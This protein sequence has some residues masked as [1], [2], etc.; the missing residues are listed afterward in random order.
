MSA[1]NAR[2]EDET[3]SKLTESRAALDKRV[4]FISRRMSRVKNLL[5]EVDSDVPSP[6]DFVSWLAL[7]DG[8]SELD[9]I[10]PELL[11]LRD[12]F[13][14]ELEKP[15][16][17]ARLK[18]RM[19][20][21]QKLEM[22]AEQHGFEIEKIGESPLVYF[23]DPLTLE[24]DFDRGSAMILY[25]KE[26]IREVAVSAKAVA[27]AYREIA[28]D[29]DERALES[30]AFFD[31]LLKAYRTVLLA[32]DLQSGERIDLVDVLAPLALLTSERDHW[33]DQD[34]DDESAFDRVLL[35]YQLAQLRRDGML[36]RQGQRIDLGTATGGTTRDKRN[37]LFVPVGARDG[38]FYGSLRFNESA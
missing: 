6:G 37:V 31:T 14:A 26:P 23:A 13:L 15:L 30:E 10:E 22:Q 4:R 24:V 34:R 25:G 3:P 12:S 28:A 38:Q 33:R 11:E 18:A 32:D 16:E 5:D 2:S 17:R 20:F 27:S 35:A 21:V 29:L 7:R 8:L 9:L 19:T 36:E 1:K